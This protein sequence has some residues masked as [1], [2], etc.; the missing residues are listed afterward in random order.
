M[1]RKRAENP[2]WDDEAAIGHCVRSFR[3]SIAVWWEESIPSDT[4]PKRLKALTTSW[5]EFKVAF[6]RAWKIKSTMTLVA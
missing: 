3:N 5:K 4:S 1:A 6:R 2:A